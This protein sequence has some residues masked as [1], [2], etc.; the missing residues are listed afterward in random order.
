[1]QF[2]MVIQHAEVWIYFFFSSR[3]RHTR[4]TVGKYASESAWLLV[5]HADHDLAFQKMCLDLMKAQAAG[6]VS[7][8]NMACLED[9]G[10]VG[11][12]RPQFY[13]TQFYADEAG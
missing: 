9:R 5:Q 8:A 12:G 10:R 1:M 11:E 3:R 6:E 2:D 7:P 4:S 13:G